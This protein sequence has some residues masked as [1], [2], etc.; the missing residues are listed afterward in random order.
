MRSESLNTIKIEIKK[1]G[2]IT[3]NKEKYSEC[4][5]KMYE[6]TE[7]SEGNNDFFNKNFDLL[8]RLLKKLLDDYR[9]ESRVVILKIIKFMIRNVTPSYLEHY[10]DNIL[11]IL[12]PS[13][14][15]EKLI[16]SLYAIIDENMDRYF[17]I[18]RKNPTR[19]HE[20]FKGLTNSWKYCNELVCFD[21]YFK[22]T[23]ALLSV[24][25]EYGIRYIRDI[26]FLTC[27]KEKS[28]YME[29]RKLY[30]SHINSVLNMCLTLCDLYPEYVVFFKNKIKII[31]D[32]I[33]KHIS[34][35]VTDGVTINK[36]DM[37]NTV[38]NRIEEK[39]KL[40]VDTILY[41]DTANT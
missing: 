21:Y 3:S 27:D 36:D 1:L 35:L 38:N 29:N 33:N 40:D 28:L 9:S 2:D 12:T 32:N 24:S 11:D 4:I 31:I 18:F 25:G 20:H 10:S 17:I 14:V 13:L 22:Y 19:V 30:K 39:C 41:E 23:A 37:I 7:N 26:V 15:D 34:E 5:N 6:L 8:L 16:E